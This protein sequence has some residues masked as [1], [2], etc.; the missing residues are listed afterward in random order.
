[1]TMF[2]MLF[3]YSEWLD[4]EGLIVSDHGHAHIGRSDGAQPIEDKRTHEDLVNEFLATHP[5]A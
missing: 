5:H 4:S 3:A 1:M 2:A